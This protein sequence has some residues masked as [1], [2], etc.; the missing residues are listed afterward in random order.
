V[1]DWAK[2]FPARRLEHLP[3]GWGIVLDDVVSAL[4]MGALWLICLIFLANV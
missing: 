1:A 4:Y 2:P 3:G